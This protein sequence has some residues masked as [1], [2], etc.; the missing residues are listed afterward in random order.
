MGANTNIS[1][2]NAAA[3]EQVFTMNQ[4]DQNG[5]L[6]YYN[7][8]AIVALGHKRVSLSIRAPKAAG[9][10]GA[11]IGRTY[12]VQLN[13]YAPTLENPGTTDGGYSA[14]PKKAYENVCQVTFLLAERSTVLERQDLRA[15]LVDLF[16]EANAIDM[17]D[18]FNGIV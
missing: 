3:V 17:I 12:K 14:V 7:R 15:M 13:L 6:W 5:V 10:Q 8:T 1:L 18:N 4:P 16:T 11:D 9:P 2:K